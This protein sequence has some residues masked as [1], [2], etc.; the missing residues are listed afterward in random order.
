MAEEQ[1]LLKIGINADTKGLNS[2]NTQFNQLQRGINTLNSSLKTGGA[3]LDTY[4]AK[5]QLLAKQLE[6]L[7]QK[8]VKCTNVINN[9]SKAMQENRTKYDEL[10]KAE[11]DHSSELMK[12]DNEYYKMQNAVNKAE[13]EL[14][15]LETQIR[16]TTKELNNCNTAVENFN[17][18]KLSEHLQEQGK[19]LQELGD[20]WSNVGTTITNVGTGVVKAFAPIET[21]GAL[22]VKCAIDFES[23]WASAT[24]TINGT[25]EELQNL[26]D[27]LRG[28]SKEMPTN[29]NDLNELAAAAGQMG[30]GVNDVKEYVRVMA[31]LGET[32]NISADEATTSLAQLLNITQGNVGEIS[33]LGSAIV[34]LGNNLATDEATIVEFAQR[35]AGVGASANMSEQ[36]IL[37][38]SAAM[39]ALGINAEAGGTSFSTFVSKI[40]LACSN[41]GESLQEF[42]QVAGMSSEEF[43]KSFDENSTDAIMAVVKGMHDYQEAGGDLISLISNL[44]ISETRQRDLLLRLAQGYDIV[45]D[46][47][48][49][50]NEAW[51]ENTAL[52]EEANK[53]YQTT[54]SQMEML[55]NKVYDVG[56]SIGA[57]LLPVINDMIDKVGEAVEW[58]GQLPPELSANIIKFSTLATGAGLLTAGFGKLVSGI[59]G[60]IKTVGKFVSW[61]GKLVAPATAA[62][63]ALQGVTTATAGIST[64]SAS[65]GVIAS[66]TSAL[67]A[68]APVAVPVI[69]ALAAIGGGIVA[70]KTNWAGF[71]DTCESVTEDVMRIFNV[72]KE[73]MMEVFGHIKEGW[74]EDFGNIRTMLE[75]GW[76][77]ITTIFST[78]FDVIENLFD[79]FADG[80]EGDWEGVWENV[81]AITDELF[82][83]FSEAWSNALDTML[84]VMDDIFPGI[85]DKLDFLPEVWKDSFNAIGDII[86]EGIKNIKLTFEALGKIFNGDFSG[87]WDMFVDR[88]SE[89][90]DKVK[91]IL[92]ST[93]DWIVEKFTSM[94]DVVS[95]FATNF[96]DGVIEKYEE[97][98]DGVIETFGNMKEG[99]VN[100]VD[101]IKEGVVTKWEEIKEEV[102]QKVDEI[103]EGVT[104]KVNEMVDTVVT[105]FS[106]LPYKIAYELGAVSG[107]IANWC[108]SVYDYLTTNVPMWIESMGTWF[109]ELPN[110]I[111]VWL[112]T[113]FNGIKDWGINT[114]NSCTETAQKSID[115]VNTFFSTLPGKVSTWLNNTLNNVIT[116]GTNMKNKAVESATNFVN[117][118]IQKLSELPGKV[119]SKLDEALNKVKSWGTN[120]VNSAKTSASQIISAIDSGLSSLP[121]IALKWGAS[122]PSKIWSGISSGLSSLKTKVS[123]MLSGLVNSAIEGFKSTFGGGNR[124]HG[125]VINTPEI[126]FTNEPYGG[127]TGFELI[128]GP[129]MALSSPTRK[130]TLT[131]LGQGASVKS[132]LTS[133]QMMLDA[134]KE[135]V[136]R[137]IANV[138]FD[139]G[140]SSSSLSRMAFNFGN[141]QQNITNTTNFD[142]GNIVNALYEFMKMVGGMNMSPQI[143]LSAKSIAK[144]TA[145]YIDKELQWRAK[146][147]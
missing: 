1:L 28:L 42:A 76:E 136:Q 26:Q 29:I 5:Q 130:G 67:S 133:T 6:T 77:N 86:G 101:E 7:Q 85:K 129:A 52:Q 121:S 19:H 54:A 33:N 40:Q 61:I 118:C 123:N 16:D 135:E 131:L 55:K 25:D 94:V 45:E 39:G 115:S 117:S 112:D 57:Q 36:D 106:E 11:G 124:E 56:I 31:M 92:G 116:W 122:I 13:T 72:W 58:F 103:K 142:D 41:G 63:T 69:G 37:G 132:N 74:E 79:L 78:V 8:Q 38:F 88:W 98:K 4:K 139:Y 27:G 111:F 137:Q 62:T 97:V 10:S 68:L 110:K 20:K 35:I 114:Y 47:L 60:G 113:T 9:Y 99:I 75:T 127:K 134:V 18:L 89:I 125:G 23:S 64:A 91:D 46:S 104:T 51:A 147:R 95:E 82:E 48:G 90:W 59:G 22:A 66:L 102:P 84:V 96:K 120:A 145:P 53:R 146:K 87:S 108:I 80:F 109:S 144:A 14:A 50:S 105:F 24:K 138:Y 93:K 2:L 143:N 71:R 128:D 44:G 81:F 34:D 17:R 49:I 140:M 70:F 30:I 100:K 3:S 65:T 107:E 12:L 32:T 73:R 21:A 141:P 119:K 15:T 83:G 43:K 126:S